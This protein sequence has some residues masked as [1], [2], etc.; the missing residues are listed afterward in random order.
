[1][2]S[3]YPLHPRDIAQPSADAGEYVHIELGVNGD[4]QGT[5]V[6]Y[7]QLYRL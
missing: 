3:F 5:R 7:V 1:M 4:D 6:V 2:S